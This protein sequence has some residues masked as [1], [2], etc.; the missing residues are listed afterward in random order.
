MHYNTLNT[1]TTQMELLITKNDASQI[2]ADDVHSALRR[3]TISMKAVPVLFGM[4][5]DPS[6][7]PSPNPIPSSSPSPSPNPNPNSNPNYDSNP[8]SIANTS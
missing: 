4:F 3:V 5:Q 8:N 1:F 2:S 6:P 7:S